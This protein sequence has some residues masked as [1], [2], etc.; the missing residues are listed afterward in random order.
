MHTI[1][2]E[3]NVLRVDKIVRRRVR[4]KRRRVRVPIGGWSN[5]ANH[6]TVTKSTFEFYN[7]DHH[8]SAMR[9][10]EDR[11]RR[12]AKVPRGQQIVNVYGT[13]NEGDQSA[14]LDRSGPGGVGLR[15]ARGGRRDAAR[16]ARARGGTCRAP[17][18]STLRW[19]RVC[20][21]GQDVDGGKVADE[22]QVGIPFLTGSEEERGPLFDVTKEHFESRRAPAGMD[23][24]GRK[25]FP[26][27]AG[28]GVPNGVPLMAVR[29]GKRMI[30]SLPGEGTKEVG[31]RI[32]AAAGAGDLG[33][34]R[35]RRWCS[36]AWPTSSSSTSRPREEYE[37]QHYE[38]GNTHFGRVS[39]VLMRERDRQARGRRS[40]AARPRRRPTPSTPPT[41]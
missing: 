1:D 27:G 28:G 10:F 33:L 8:A 15:G 12:S 35:S 41:A 26:P 5:F 40:P 32:K 2:P 31:A 34:G 20:F 38:G 22:S 13:S 36:R 37:K 7:A 39:S 16:M 11:I 6:G 18:R 24:H 29:V 4:G 3:V 23:P 30:V 19:T 9:V 17:R 14:G 21:C 25:I